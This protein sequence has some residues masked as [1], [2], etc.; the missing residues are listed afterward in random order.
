LDFIIDDKDDDDDDDDVEKV[1][2]ASS[3]WVVGAGRYDDEEDDGVAII[4]LLLEVFWG[5]REKVPSSTRDHVSEWN[6][7]NASS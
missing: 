7:S 2:E 1:L 3:F 4:G 6:S 5:K